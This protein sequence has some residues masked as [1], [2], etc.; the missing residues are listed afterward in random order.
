MSSS[1]FM[2]LSRTAAQ[3]ASFDGVIFTPYFLSMPS[4]DAITT[5][6][7]SVSGMKPIFTSVFSGASVPAAQAPART[8]GSTSDSR[9][10]PATARA[11]P[12]SHLRRPAL[13]A[14]SPLAA[15][16]EGLRFTGVMQG[17]WK[18]A[19]KKNVPRATETIRW[20]CGTSL[21]LAACCGALRRATAVGR[22]GFTQAI[23]VPGLPRAGRIGPRGARILALRA[24]RRAARNAAE[25]GCE[26]K[27]CAPV[28][29][30]HHP[31]AGRA[32]PPCARPSRRAQARWHGTCIF[33]ASGGISC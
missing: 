1:P 14:M 26:P 4:T 22:P 10:A 20:R 9:L 27:W 15:W 21:S 19:A 3:D 30:A 28:A 23:P 12:L 2:S 5:D 13:A 11:V 8:S 31:R 25:T 18:K 16:V 24:G 33:H 32:P 29:A 6:A 17:S 7:Q